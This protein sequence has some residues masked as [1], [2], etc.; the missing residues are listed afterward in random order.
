MNFSLY[1]QMMKVNVKGVMNYAIGAAF[2]MILMVWLYPSMEETAKPLNDMLKVMPAGVTK[3]FNLQNGFGSFESFISGEFY[4]LL[5]TLIVSIFCVMVPIQLMA[6]LVDQGS[7][8]YLLSTPT[9]RGKVAFT[10]ASVF[11]TGLLLISAITTICGIVGVHI[12]IDNASSFHIDRFIQLNLA[13]FALF[14]A[15][16]GISFLVSSLS[17]DEKKALG[18][19]GMIIFGLYSLDI[20]GKISEKV[21]WLKNFTIFTL[22]KPG[23]IVNGKANITLDCIILFLIGIVAFVIAILIFKKRDLPL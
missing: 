2:Y 13:A 12:F 15:L 8:G 3:A 17:N 16:G 6:K 9:T 11:V 14:V 7:M 19:S 1:K 5:F 18:T 4:G 23:D 20:V 10:Q 21:E 22:Y